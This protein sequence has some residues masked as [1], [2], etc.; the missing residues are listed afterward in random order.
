VPGARVHTM[1]S[2]AFL[3]VLSVMA[4][5]IGGAASYALW[6]SMTY[7]PERREYYDA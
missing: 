5:S 6:R 4:A 3:L 2:T 1:K 7:R